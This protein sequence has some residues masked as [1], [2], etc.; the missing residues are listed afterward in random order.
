MYTTSR[1]DV[2]STLTSFSCTYFI[3]IVFALLTYVP[4]N[5]LDSPFIK[6]HYSIYVVIVS[7]PFSA[8]MRPMG[9]GRSL[10]QLEVEDHYGLGYR[11]RS[12][13][14]TVERPND[15]SAELKPS[16]CTC[17]HIPLESPGE[18]DPRL[19]TITLDYIFLNPRS[20]FLNSNPHLP[21]L[22]LSLLSL[23]HVRTIQP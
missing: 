10:Y 4:A 12:L 3:P 8:R 6:V 17:K 20:I 11:V 16:I 15:Y 18:N 7:G 22:S 5:N 9:K 19:H 13:D 1:F 21:H 14:S 23:N 2:F